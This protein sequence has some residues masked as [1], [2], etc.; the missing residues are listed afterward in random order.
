MQVIEFDQNDNSKFYS[1]VSC[2]KCEIEKGRIFWDALRKFLVYKI[3][4]VFKDF[5][6]KCIGLKLNKF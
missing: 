6:I 5:P 4:I 3:F 2:F 1:G